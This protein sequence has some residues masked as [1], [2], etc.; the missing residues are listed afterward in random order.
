MR[1]I[2]S[3]LPP[4]LF[5]LSAIFFPNFSIGQS[6]YT[7]SVSFIHFNDDGSFLFQLSNG[8]KLIIIDAPDCEVKNVFLVR[9]SRMKVKYEKMVRMRNDIRDIFLA[10]VGNLQ[11]SVS[12]FS[13]DDTG[14]PMVE[15]IMFGIKKH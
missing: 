1:A 15:N 8:N 9:K 2:F 11:I 12:V 5:L 6:I 4:T 13:C 10:K 3:Q 14:F 7:G